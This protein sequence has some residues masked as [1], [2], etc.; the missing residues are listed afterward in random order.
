MTNSNTC[1]CRSNEDPVGS[2]SPQDKRVIPNEYKSLGSG[3]SGDIGKNNSQSVSAY[4]EQ[5]NSLEMEISCNSMECR[6]LGN[7]VASKTLILFED[8][9]ATL[10]EDRGLIATILELAETTKRPIILT[11]NSKGIVWLAIS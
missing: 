5:E 3:N 8:F 4:R 1:R 2:Q 10:D 6:S 11:S 9:D 7:Q